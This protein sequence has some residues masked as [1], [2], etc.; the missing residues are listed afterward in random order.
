[1]NLDEKLIEELKIQSQRDLNEAERILKNGG[2]MEHVAWHCEQAYEK[3][4]KQIY[5]YFK[6][7]IQSANVVSVYDKL[8]EK[9]HYGSYKLIIN[10]FREILSSFR[11]YLKNTF[12]TIDS[13][14]DQF[15]TGTFHATSS[16]Y[17]MIPNFNKQLERTLSN[18]EIKIE[19]NISNIEAFKIF[20][21]NA[22]EANINKILQQTNITKNVNDALNQAKTNA[23]LKTGDVLFDEIVKQV[24]NNPIDFIKFYGFISQA[25]VLATWILPHTSMSRYPSIEHNFENLQ[26]YRNRDSTLVPFFR[27]L[28]NEIKNLG[29]G[30]N[31]FLTM[32]HQYKKNGT[33]Q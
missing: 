18:V 23:V 19:K 5:A 14:S 11:V 12:Q 26:L 31:D 7:K 1:M 16:L 21:N 8:Y 33:I 22:T 32:L 4:V 2:H 30:S 25:L 20:L 3:I 28:I 29:S 15:P 9:Q 27:I 10:M 17:N 24:T 6:L 13:R